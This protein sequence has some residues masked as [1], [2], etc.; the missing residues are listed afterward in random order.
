[1]PSSKI[2]LILLIPSKIPRLRYFGS[3]S[4]SCIGLVWTSPGVWPP[5]PMKFWQFQTSHDLSKSGSGGSGIGVTLAKFLTIS[6]GG[7]SAG[8][9]GFVEWLMKRA[10][11]FG[12]ADWA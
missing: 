1:M 4:E 11:S 10:E 3:A 12:E 2:M 9:F 7:G 5:K 8:C 6:A